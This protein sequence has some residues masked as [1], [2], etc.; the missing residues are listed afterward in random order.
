M[1][2]RQPT[3]RITRLS[4]QAFP[5][6]DLPRQPVFF[7]PAVGFSRKPIPI[8]GRPKNGPFLETTA[9]HLACG[10]HPH[11]RSKGHFQP[12]S[13][14]PSAAGKGFKLT[15]VSRCAV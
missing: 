10:G 13:A 7:L 3:A 4:R 6:F 5:S 15:A 2:M 1:E 9:I 8:L 11:L 12:A 14:C